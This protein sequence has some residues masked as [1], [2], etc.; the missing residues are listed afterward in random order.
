MFSTVLLVNP[1]NADLHC[2]DNRLSLRHGIMLCD[3]PWV[4][5]LV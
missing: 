4:H 3:N 5:V 2:F 1:F